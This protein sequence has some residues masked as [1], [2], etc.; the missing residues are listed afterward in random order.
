V[1]D[2]AQLQ[3]L[4]FEWN[5]LKE[6]PAFISNMRALTTVKLTG[7]DLEN[8]PNCLKLP[9]TIRKTLGNNCRITQN[10]TRIAELKRRF[11][12]VIFD[13]SDEYDCPAK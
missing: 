13:F 10:E 9:S 8:L 11:P 6:L 1:K 12:N 2:L 4:G 3:E 7:N 5:K